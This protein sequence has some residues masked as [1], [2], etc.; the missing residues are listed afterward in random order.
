M[1]YL[2]IKCT[3]IGIFVPEIYCEADAQWCTVAVPPA[4]AVILD[5]KGVVAGDTVAGYHEGSTLVL[6]CD[7]I[8]GRE[9]FR[10]RFI[11]TILRY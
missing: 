11:C 10:P 3:R 8:G 7:I 5:E 4:E 9:Q 2:H 6:T 1:I